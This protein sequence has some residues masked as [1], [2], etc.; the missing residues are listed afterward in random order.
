MSC[1]RPQ[2]ETTSRRNQRLNQ[3]EARGQSGGHV[4][5]TVSKLASSALTPK[6]VRWVVCQLDDLRK[7]KSLAAIKEALLKLPED[8]DQ[9]YDRILLNIP[10]HYHDMAH[11]AFQWV[12]SSIEPLTVA[13]LAEAIAVDAAECS[14][15][16]DNRLLDPF[17]ILEICS[18]MITLHGDYVR[19][20]HFT[21]Q[22]CMISTHIQQG[23]ASSF[24]VTELEAHSVMAKTCLTYFQYFTSPNTEGIGDNDA[25]GVITVDHSLIFM[26]ENPLLEY[27]VFRWQDHATIVEKSSRQMEVTQ[28]CLNLLDPSLG[29]K[30]FSLDPTIQ[31]CETHRRQRS[32]LV[33]RLAPVT[34]DHVCSP[35]PQKEKWRLLFLK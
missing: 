28:L 16:P 8:L 31:L 12:A 35:R 21:V 4:G 30:K 5:L 18:T 1:N 22:E 2:A 13:A 10:E 29:L 14:F 3:R 27:A 7:L 34:E 17:E 11:A 20:A 23:P 19:F 15:N 24:Y 6:R 32:F 25:V 9:T 33:C 26:Q